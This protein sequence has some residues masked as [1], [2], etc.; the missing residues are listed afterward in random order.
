MT[1]TVI[2]FIATLL[3][4]ACTASYTYNQLDW[5]IPWYVDDYVD[6]TRSQR[7]ALQA[8]LAPRLAW[9]RE[10]ELA[11]Y[12]ALL[13]RI[14]SGLEETVDARTVY[15]WADDLLAAAQRVER[16]MMEVALDFGPE[17]SEEQMREF[18]GTLWERQ[19]E[20]EEEFLERS[21]AEYAEDDFEYMTD[22]LERFLGRL[23][24]DQSSALRAAANDL[25]R[26]DR[27]WL[28]E[29]RAW[30]QILEPLLLNRKP[31]WQ[32]AVMN[33]YEVRLRERTPAYHATLKHNLDRI[34]EAYARALS[35]MSDRQRGRALAE[36][37]DLRGTLLKL[38]DRPGVAMGATWNDYSWARRSRLAVE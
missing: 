21:D 38:M 20:Y 29:R 26:F 18:I 30:L 22:L 33:A 9:H 4:S 25:Q 27:A 35:I 8:Q 34:S 11:Q 7:Q 1:R 31:G 13:D 6:L 5:L 36:I 32:E 23:S 12:V 24:P 3:L 17:V 37:E 14:E 2:A 28:Q 10:E 15:G 16:T 19:D